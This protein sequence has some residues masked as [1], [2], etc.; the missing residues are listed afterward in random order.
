[1]HNASV[2]KM[3]KRK[4]VQVNSIPLLERGGGSKD[5]TIHAPPTLPLLALPV[6]KQVSVLVQ[7]HPSLT[8]H[9]NLFCN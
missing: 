9:R 1:M 2:K 6:L 8:G 5:N 4:D 7:L 3:L